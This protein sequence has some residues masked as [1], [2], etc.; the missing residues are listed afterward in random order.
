[1]AKITNWEGPTDVHAPAELP[2]GAAEHE[3]ADTPQTQTEGV[4]IEHPVIPDPHHRPVTN[5]IADPAGDHE[6]KDPTDPE[7]LGVE[8]AAAPVT[9]DETAADGVH[10]E[11]APESAVA[12]PGEEVEDDT[13]AGAEDDTE[14]PVRPLQSDRKDAWVAYAV[15][16]DDDLTEADAQAMTKADLVE[17]YG[18]E[19]E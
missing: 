4:V 11:E 14:A 3:V 17:R 2:D 15:A 9:D 8:G 19:V 16:V 13:E 12:S 5:P 18:A 6:G 1:M 7:A 10:Q